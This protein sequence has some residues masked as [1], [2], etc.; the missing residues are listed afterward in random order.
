MANWVKRFLTVAVLAPL[1]VTLLSTRGGSQFLVVL[2][3][4]LPL[5]EFNSHVA[6]AI[7]ARLER[8]GAAPFNVKPEFGA[9]PCFY[10]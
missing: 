9:Y 10:V 4:A 8:K 5:W 6:P 3:T 2:V 7:V 1:A